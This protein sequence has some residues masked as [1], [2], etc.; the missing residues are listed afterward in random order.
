[1]LL[2]SRTSDAGPRPS[3]C[4]A[5]ANS[6]GVVAACSLVAARRARPDRTRSASNPVLV[7]PQQHDAFSTAGARWRDVHIRRNDF[8]SEPSSTFCAR[9]ALLAHGGAHGDPGRRAQLGGAC[10]TT[11][12][13]DDENRIYQQ[14]QYVGQLG[15]S[16]SSNGC[17]TSS[18]GRR[19]CEDDVLTGEAVLGPGALLF[20]LT[21]R[22][23]R[24]AP[25]P[26]SW[27]PTRS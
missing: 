3:S 8:V 15:G 11:G 10:P 4:A 1:M 20:S 19:R 5:A 17:E 23:P 24:T 22:W 7:E 27:S 16:R 6:P 21:F 14:V 26:P 2:T 13:V 9:G 18:A 12:D 25:C